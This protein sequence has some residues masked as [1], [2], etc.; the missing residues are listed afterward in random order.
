[1]IAQMVGVFDMAYGA[2][3]WSSNGDIRLDTTS[4]IAML[5][6][7][8]TITKAANN[9]STKTETF[10]HSEIT[11]NNFFHLVDAPS[12]DF[13]RLI[14][15]SVSGNTVTITMNGSIDS[16]LSGTCIVYIGVYG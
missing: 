3:V 5:I 13:H 15:T 6:G 11:R 1:M 7:S 14:T 8:V 10:T 12:L 9:S 16:A 2:N 4:K